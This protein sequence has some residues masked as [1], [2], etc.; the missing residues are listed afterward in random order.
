MSTT[1]HAAGFL[2]WNF[3]YSYA[4]L[5]PR[6]LKRYLKIDHN[7]APREDINK[8]AVRM[9]QEGKMKQSTLDL[10]K[11]CRAA[12]ENSMEGYPLFVGAVLFALVAKL[13]NGTINTTCAV[14]T[15]ARLA[16]GACYLLTETERMSWLR[17]L[18]WYSGTLSCL[19][20]IW[21]GGNALNAG[22]L[23]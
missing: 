7:A 16:Y 15:A 6:G 13:D 1:N 20:L 11:R 19:T 21:K 8:Y 23:A 3:V 10:L 4:I 2:I 5:A 12:H 18:A 22:L 14:Y 17:T 9:V